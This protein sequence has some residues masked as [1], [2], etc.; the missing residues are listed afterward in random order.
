ML[1][2]LS[3]AAVAVSLEEGVDGAHGSVFEIIANMPV[4]ADALMP[5]HGISDLRLIVLLQQMQ[6]AIL[7]RVG[8]LLQIHSLMSIRQADGHIATHLV[9]AKFGASTACRLREGMIA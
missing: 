5:A 9:N 6:Q 7:R 8:C 1:D 4:D 3:A 2:I